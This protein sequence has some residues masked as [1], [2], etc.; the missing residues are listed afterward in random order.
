MA[1]NM[2]T[3][4]ETLIGL[5][6]LAAVLCAGVVTAQTPDTLF[7][8]IK[9]E[10]PSPFER[11]QVTLYLEIYSAPEINLSSAFQVGGFPAPEELLIQ[12][13]EELAAAPVSIGG[14]S[15]EMRRFRCLARAPKAGTIRCAP[16]LRA[17]V[18]ALSRTF[19]MT[20]R[21][22]QPVSIPVTPLDLVVRPIPTE[23]RPLDYSGLVGRFAFACAVA[24]TN[25]TPG[26]LVTITITVSGDGDMEAMAPPRFDPGPLFK[27]YDPEL[28]SS[29]SRADK[30]VFRQTL[31]PLTTNSVLIPT[32]SISYFDPAE[33]AFRQAQ[34]GPFHLAV[35]PEPP[36]APTVRRP[37]RAVSSSEA[38]ED[39]TLIKPAPA[40]WRQKHAPSPHSLVR[41][42]RG[43]PA[44]AVL[45]MAAVRLW[46]PRN[47]KTGVALQV[48]AVLLLTVWLV[49]EGLMVVRK[50]APAAADKAASDQFRLASERFK[51]GRFSEAV[52]LYAR[53]L[54]D[55]R[56]A[57][58]LFH[59]L[60]AACWKAG[61]K[62]EAVLNYRRALLLSPRNTATRAMLRRLS[63]NSNA[64]IPLW[65]IVSPSEQRTVLIAL[66]GL[67][68][69]LL[70]I[71]LARKR[72]ARWLTTAMATCAAALIAGAVF[73][74]AIRL[75]NKCEA[76]ILTENIPVRIAPSDR[77][78]ATGAFEEG[79]VVRLSEPEGI[80]TRAA[81]ERL[82]GWIPSSAV[83]H[84]SW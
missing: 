62:G 40:V 7:A 80:W 38:Q 68:A 10:P 76:V 20:L 13:F 53:I 24:P 84:T 71:R 59:N 15:Y 63:P 57:P 48:V 29:Q 64:A 30:R 67:T 52:D 83:R 35:S 14:K 39:T 78:L 49:T 72:S 51:E 44:L 18:I 74:P 82:T 66:Y 31:V 60:G 70:T 2:Q 54:A 19:F 50:P 56:Y 4:K 36:A 9:A 12:P 1:P 33:E 73:Q 75:P 17:S 45:L 55:G 5:S 37:P 42:V 61:R 34:L 6:L 79:E 41:P 58:E 26:D 65:R 28:D 8:R 47:R 23:G 22:E 81:G 32:A 43:L 25:P 77:A 16:V 3:E 21:E 11:Q 46:R 69:I 27:A